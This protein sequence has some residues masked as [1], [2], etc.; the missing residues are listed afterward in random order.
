[1]NL[2]SFLI[3]NH[4]TPDIPF[5]QFD[6]VISCLSFTICFA[7]QKISF[8]CSGSFQNNKLTETGIVN[9]E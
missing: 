6:P 8:W 4:F 9:K 7:I 1:M 2:Y 5:R 3:Y